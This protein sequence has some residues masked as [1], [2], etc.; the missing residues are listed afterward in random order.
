MMTATDDSSRLNASPRILVEVNS[1]ISPAMTAGQA[2]DA[3]DAVA[4]LEHP[5]RPRG[6]PGRPRAR[7]SHAVRT[8][9]ISSGLN[10]IAAPRQ[11]LISDGLDPGPDRAVEDLVADLDDHPAQQVRVDRRPRSPD[12]ARWPGRSPVAVARSVRP[13]AGRPT[14][15]S[16]G[17]AWPARPAGR[18]RRRPRAGPATSRSLAFSTLQEVEHQVADLALERLLD[19]RGL[20]RPLD[21]RGRQGRLDLGD[22]AYTSVTR[23]RSSSADL[24]GLAALRRRRR[25]GPRRRRGRP[26]ARTT[27]PRRPGFRL[28][29]LR[30]LSSSRFS[31]SSP[32]STVPAT[33]DWN[34]DLGLAQALAMPRFV[35]RSARASSSSRVWSAGVSSR[36]IALVDTRAASCTACW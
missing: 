9:T 2:V 24:L 36:L 23:S 20:G 35:R 22:L 28:R 32:Q 25:A 13:S 11:Q 3:G 10:F 27:L 16:P 19:D 8:E 14:G 7:R 5:C 4:D 1:T 30:P 34:C 18:G 33:W 6:R 15:P 21:D 12:P 29:R 31:V 26:A 17:P